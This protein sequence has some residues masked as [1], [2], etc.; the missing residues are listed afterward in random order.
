M[1]ARTLAD[2]V[3][4][5]APSGAVLGEVPTSQ[6]LPWTSVRVRVPGVRDR[7][8]AA[9]PLGRSVRVQVTCA[10]LTDEQVLTVLDAALSALEGARPVAAGWVAGPLLLIGDPSLYSDDVVAT[11]VNRR[12]AVAVA[13]LECTASPIA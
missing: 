3:L 9:T 12:V 2:A 8:D 7:S 6:A 4:A 10:G 13:S 1:T 5:L 11:G